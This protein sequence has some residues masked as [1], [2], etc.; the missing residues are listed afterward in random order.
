MANGNAV[1]TTTELKKI[2][3][4]ELKNMGL[5]IGRTRKPV[6]LQ[7]TG[8]I[9]ADGKVNGKRLAKRMLSDTLRAYKRMYKLADGKVS[10]E[11]KEFA[12]AL[13][14]QQIDY[15]ENKLAAIHESVMEALRTRKRPAADL[16]EFPD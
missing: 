12:V 4:D 15:M 3:R 8:N 16:E 10:R 1:P 5:S 6:D 7:S 11:K 13:S 9:E 2:S 14:D